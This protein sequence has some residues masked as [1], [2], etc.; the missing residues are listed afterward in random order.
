VLR[1]VL[2][3]SRKAYSEAVER[4]TTEN[5]IRALENAF[6][7]FGGVPQTLVLDNLKAAVTRADWFDPELNPKVQSFCQH[8]GIVA[9]P[10]KPYTPRHKGK[11]ERG[12]DYVQENGLKGHQFA[13]LSQENAHL[14]HWEATVAD[15]RIH[16]TTRKQ[17]QQVFETAERA[18]LQPLPA[19]RFPCFEEAARTVHRDGHVE[20]A[21]AYYSV[22]PEHLGRRVWVRWDS[23]LVRIF[24]ARMELIA[25]HV[26]QEAGRF[27]TQD[28]HLLDQKISAVERGASWLLKKTT[29]LGQASQRWAEAMVQARGIEGVRVL[30][31]L[32]SLGQRHAPAQLDRACGLALEHGCF[33]LRTLRRLLQRDLD[34]ADRQAE[35]PELLDEHPIIRSLADYGQFVH[36]AFL[37]P[38]GAQETG[39]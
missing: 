20:V 10:T 9:L 5:F 15:R 32:L 6:W 27:S 3:H 14:Q 22:P 35:L 12:V 21:K 29:H 31:G 28:R 8:Y 39:T 26:R 18:A 36:S 30:Q 1:V 16:G 24:D 34:H 25:T 23:H 7:H 13:S 19:T 38:A 33:R 37:Q 2:S 17:V 4:Q 11:V